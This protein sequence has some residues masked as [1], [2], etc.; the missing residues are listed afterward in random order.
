MPTSS[1]SSE[2]TRIPRPLIGAKRP[3]ALTLHPAT[4]I[5]ASP[6]RPVPKTPGVSLPG[7]SSSHA[8]M[9]SERPRSLFRDLEPHKR[10]CLYEDLDMGSTRGHAPTG[11]ISSILILRRQGR[12]PLF[13]PLPSLPHPNS[14]L[15][16]YGWKP[17]LPTSFQDGNEKG[18]KT[19]V[20]PVKSSIIVV[21]DWSNL[22]VSFN[23][24]GEVISFSERGSTSQS[25]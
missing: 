25:L 18:P 24:F 2:P 6:P 17:F 4:R 21:N 15:S 20:F 5:S 19:L 11:D 9:A 7:A 8:R 22:Q 14:W 13:G 10:V 23:P 12:I 16:P 3:A 1:I